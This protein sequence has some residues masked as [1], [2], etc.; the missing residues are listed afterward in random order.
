MRCCI[1]PVVLQWCSDIGCLSPARAGACTSTTTSLE[2]QGRRQSRMTGRFQCERSPSFEASGAS[3]ENF[4]TSQLAI[5]FFNENE[6]IS[7]AL[8][9]KSSVVNASA[10][11]QLVGQSGQQDV[12]RW[13]NSCRQRFEARNWKR[14]LTFLFVIWFSDPFIGPYRKSGPRINY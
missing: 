4:P 5:P 3:Y 11:A 7:A 14:D 1:L 9:R 8:K 2:G 13:L 12:V 10:S 6:W